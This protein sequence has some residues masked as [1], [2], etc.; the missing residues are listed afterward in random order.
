LP[1]ALANSSTHHAYRDHGEGYCIFNDSV[2]AI[3]AL[4]HDGTLRR[5][6]VLDCDVH[7]GNGTAALVADDPSIY[8]FSIHSERNYPLRK[9][10]SDLDIGL[11]DGTDDATYLDA[12]ELGLRQ[13]IDEA[14]AE[15]AIYLAGADPYFGDRLGRLS[16]TKFG[17]AERDRMVFD[18]CQAKG[19]PVAVTMAGGYAPKVEDIVDIHFQTV[20]EAARR[21]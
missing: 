17:L 7:Q 2:V 10:R 3:R 15:L 19:I 5:V 4:Q 13:S 8:A 20:Q 16:L 18:H 11:E 14:R 12:L 9:E 21:A 6:V 1:D